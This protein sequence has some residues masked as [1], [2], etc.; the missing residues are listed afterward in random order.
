LLDAVAIG[1]ELI[2]TTTL[3]VATHPLAVTV[4]VYVPL[5]ADVELG[6]VGF[7]K[8]EVYPEGPVHA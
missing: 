6:L 7:C 2:V 4:T 5:I 3:E 1:A 8:V